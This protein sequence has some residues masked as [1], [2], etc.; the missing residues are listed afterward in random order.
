MQKQ[1]VRKMQKIG[2]GLGLRVPPELCQEAEVGRGDNVSLEFNPE[3]GGLKLGKVAAASPGLDDVRQQDETPESG[4]N[5]SSEN[6]SSE[7]KS[8]ENKSRVGLADE[9]E[10]SQQV[11]IVKTEFCPSCGSD[12][13]RQVTGNQFYCGD[14]ELTYEMTPEGAKVVKGNP[15]NPAN[16]SDLEAR[17]EQLENNVDEINDNSD[18][19]ENSGGLLSRL[20]IEFGFVDGY[21]DEDDED[22][23]PVG[24]EENPGSDD[25]DFDENGD[26]KGFLSW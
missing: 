18:K 20:G 15:G 6:K 25:D 24:A 8:S 22:L 13:I 3:S 16:F 14:C 12:D 2:N 7:N 1:Y 10:Q 23:V 19:D 9:K 17:V 5:K 11:E 21:E 4:E 26:P